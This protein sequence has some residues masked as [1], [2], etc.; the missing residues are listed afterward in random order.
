M[1]DLIALPATEP[2]KPDWLRTVRYPIKV[3][4]SVSAFLAAAPTRLI[5]SSS[6]L[7]VV[8]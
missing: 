7:D 3:S 2:V 8:G 1:N 5:P 6:F 4:I